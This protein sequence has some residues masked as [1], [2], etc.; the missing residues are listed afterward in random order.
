MWAPSFFMVGIHA[1]YNYMKRILLVHSRVRHELKS[2]EH[3]HYERLGEGLATFGCISTLDKL[4][5]WDD[6]AALIDGYDAAIMGGSG[7]FDFDGGRTQDDPA[8]E[9]TQII[10]SRVR[11][12]IEHVLAE[13]FPILGVCYGHQL[14]AEVCAGNV[15]H[16]AVQAK[17]G[18]FEVELTA[19]GTDD[20]LFGILP[21]RFLAQY[22]H[23]DSVTSMP[24]GA[25]LMATGAACNFAAIRYGAN[26][27]TTQFHPELA[28]ADMAQRVADT[29]GYLPEGADT[30]GLFRE[31]PEASRLVP[32]FI[33]RIVGGS[34]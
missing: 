17:V 29:P 10:F 5:T 3:A 21:S 12:L 24:L 15:R 34:I 30:R 11:P 33:E 16:D 1:I 2:R 14:I 9:T 4:R 31:S 20:P 23:K 27:Y 18:T 6:P 22:G 26:A 25:A 13:R 19:E 28:G 7:D 8:R 32:A